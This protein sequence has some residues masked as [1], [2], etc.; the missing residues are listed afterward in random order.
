MID[1]AVVGVAR[2]SIVVD[3]VTVVIL[4]TSVVVAFSGAFLGLAASAVKKPV[5][6]LTRR[7]EA[8][9]ERISTLEKWDAVRNEQL[10]S[11]MCALN[12]IKAFLEAHRNGEK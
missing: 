1:C 11:M 4:I 6:E 7:V 10:T 2:G 3:V 12:D 5:A 9:Q 8:H